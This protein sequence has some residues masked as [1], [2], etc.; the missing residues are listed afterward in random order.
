MFESKKK[1]KQERDELRCIVNKLQEEIKIIHEIEGRKLEQGVC[2]S[3]FCKFCQNYIGTI[4]GVIACS[5][6]DNAP[7]KDFKNM[8]DMY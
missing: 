5:K 3:E 7:C 2:K 6:H 4:N 1:V 8:R